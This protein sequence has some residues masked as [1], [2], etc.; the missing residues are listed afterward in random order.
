MSKS[1]NI[2]PLPPYTFGVEIECV[3]GPTM[4]PSIVAYE[5][6]Q[7]G[8]TVFDQ[9]RDYGGEDDEDRDEDYDENDDDG[10]E[11]EAAAA[12]P[13]TPRNGGY[14]TKTWTIG[15]DGSVRGQNTMEIK[16]PILKGQEGLRE[17]R[18]FCNHLRK[19][20][21]TVNRSCGL[22]VH[23]GI[24]NAEKKFNADEILMICKRYHQHQE[25]IDKFLAR[26]RT[27]DRNEFCRPLDT[28]IQS[29][30]RTL[31]TVTEPVYGPEAP[32][33]NFAR[34]DRYQREDWI[35]RGAGRFFWQ[36]DQRYHTV[37]EPI[38]KDNV[39]ALANCGTHYDRV[40]VASLGKYGTIEFRQHH[41]T[42]NGAKITNWIRF[43]LNHVEVSRMLVAEQK[44]IAQAP[45]PKKARKDTPFVGLSKTVRKHFKK[46]S[47]RLERRN[48]GREERVAAR[49]AEREAARVARREA[50]EAARRPPVA[51]PS[52]PEFDFVVDVNGMP[53]TDG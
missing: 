21:I 22:H 29:L 42:A 15:G 18:R 40:S 9:Y 34:M 7:A 39:V 13:P 19:L 36:S 31:A 11:P 49:R 6:R 35:A 50:Q 8:F 47:G 14:D 1:N 20:G 52:I 38:T 37:Q 4:H 44:Q 12:A 24:T 16:S 23:I 45:Q 43:L 33:A 17:I 32:P 51:P 53:P 30:E 28:A 5:L 41:G 27:G 46:Q 10:Y 25:Q 48:A 26:S 2:I 3:G